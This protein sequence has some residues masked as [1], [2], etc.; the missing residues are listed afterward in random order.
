MTLVRRGSAPLRAP[1]QLGYRGRIADVRRFEE[2]LQRASGLEKARLEVVQRVLRVVD[3]GAPKVALA[4]AV[5]ATPAA[6]P[7][8]TPTATASPTAIPTATATATP[9]PT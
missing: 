6:T 8:A 4:V 1:E 5:R 7:T 2:W 9:T 3:Q